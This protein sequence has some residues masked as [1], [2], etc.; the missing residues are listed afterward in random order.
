MP[1]SIEHASTKVI[2]M[3]MLHVA[4]STSDRPM[5]AVSSVSEP[6]VARLRRLITDPLS[7][8]AGSDASSCPLDV[9]EA[10]PW[11]LMVHGR[12]VAEAI[13]WSHALWLKYF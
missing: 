12:I 3:V 6:S 1:R 9:C 13:D 8:M 10:S 4:A 11:S 2:W 5:F 7:F